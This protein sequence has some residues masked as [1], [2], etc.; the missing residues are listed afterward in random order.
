MSSVDNPPTP[1]EQWLFAFSL[2]CLAVSCIPVF[3][4][5]AVYPAA[6]M[7]LVHLPGVWRGVRVGGLGGVRVWGVILC[8]SALA[9]SVCW[10]RLL[11]LAAEC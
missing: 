4:A 5:M 9:V 2:I 8:L 7:L 1:A 10:W 11:F 3:G 6:L